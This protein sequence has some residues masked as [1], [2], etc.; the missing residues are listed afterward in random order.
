M[1]SMSEAGEGS[2]FVSSA[3]PS[4]GARF[5]R[6]TLS[7]KGRGK[8]RAPLAHCSQQP[9]RARISQ[10]GL[11]RAPERVEQPARAHRGR[12][13]DTGPGTALPGAD[14]ARGPPIQA[15]FAALHPRRV[16][17]FKA[18]GHSAGGIAVAL[19]HTA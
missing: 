15:A 8:G 7:H 10:R 13:R 6:A 17:P 3:A 11:A 4:P 19:A 5:A 9:S 18:A 14:G 1:R 16:Q 2:E 12:H